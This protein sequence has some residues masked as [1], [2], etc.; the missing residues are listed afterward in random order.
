M[1]ILGLIIAYVVIHYLLNKY[2]VRELRKDSRYL[3]ES[4][5]KQGEELSN[6]LKL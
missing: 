6:K 4:I 1:Y 2:K 3:I 5:N